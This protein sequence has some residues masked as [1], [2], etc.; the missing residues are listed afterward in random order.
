MKGLLKFLFTI[1]VGALYGALFAQKSGKKLR[2]ELK[3]S[4]NPLK[5]LLEE[6]VQMDLEA[7]DTIS[8]IAKNSPALQNIINT[9][10]EQF[11][12]LVN[13]AKNMSSEQRE[14]AKEKQ[15]I[16]TVF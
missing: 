3:K 14:K 15:E 16:E 1:T 12:D 9:G 4:K 10:K 6:G 5:T 8:D 11:T 2:A 7:R 13:Q